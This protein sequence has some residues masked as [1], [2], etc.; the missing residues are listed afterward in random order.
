LDAFLA[1]GTPKPASGQP[2]RRAKR[3]AWFV[4]PETRE[5]D[6]AEQSNSG[7][8]GWTDGRAV[9]MKR[10]HERDP[11]L[12]YLTEQDRAALRSIRK[13]TR[14]WY[15][16]ESYSFDTARTRTWKAALSS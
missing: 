5:V 16:E 9:A 15:G 3:L 4:D 6:V 12:D 1:T 10:L 7:R 13:E 11:R 14:G 2:A 8:D